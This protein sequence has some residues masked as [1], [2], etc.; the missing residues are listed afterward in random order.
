M[1]ASAIVAGSGF[2]E[3]DEDG[4]LTGQIEGEHFSLLAI[5]TYTLW[6]NGPGSTLD[7]CKA[8]PRP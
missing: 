3:C 6:P 7:D 2:E 1:Q 4:R 5:T 8:K